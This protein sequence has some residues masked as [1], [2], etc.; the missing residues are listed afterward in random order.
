MKHK[1]FVSALL[2]ITIFSCNSSPE[3][4]GGTNSNDSATENN[5]V[6]DNSV[7]NG[8][9]GEW[10][11]CSES[12]SVSSLQFNVCPVITFN[13]FHT[14]ELI[15][16][17]GQNQRLLWIIEGKFL[18]LANIVQPGSEPFLPDGNYAFNFI[19]QQD[20]EELTLT[21]QGKHFTYN[22]SR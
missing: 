14:A 10:A 21:P 20:H 15:T 18:S 1:S 12:D 4:R 6:K 5:S 9:T 19:Q 11:I 22:L 13:K 7:E 2:S 3:K 17:G 8:L 16:G